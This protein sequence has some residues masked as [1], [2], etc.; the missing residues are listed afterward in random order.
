MT[1][2]KLTDCTVWFF[3]DK[4]SEVKD[5]LGKTAY[6]VYEEGCR[7]ADLPEIAPEIRVDGMVYVFK[8]IRNVTEHAD[9]W[10]IVD[11]VDFLN[12]PV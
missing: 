10:D 1:S 4:M 8:D 12:S 2:I 6:M 5:Y 3:D 9:F 7:P 11:A